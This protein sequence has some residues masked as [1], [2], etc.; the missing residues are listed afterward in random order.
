MLLGVHI[1]DVSFYV[2]EGSP[3]DREAAQRGTSVYLPDQVI[4]MLP[5][6]LSHD[7]CCLQP[8][9]DRLTLS[10]CIELAADGRMGRYEVVDTVIRSQA[11][12]TYTQVAAYLDGNPTH[13]S[14]NP[15]IGAVLA[16]MDHLASVLRQQ[17]LT[18][19]SLD[20]DLPEADI[21]LNSEGKI[22]TILRAERT[23][24]HML[25]EEFM[26]LANRTVAAHLARL[27]VPALYRVHE[28]PSAEKLMPFSAFVRTFGY[29]LPDTGRLQSRA[30]QTLLD[31]AQGTPAAPLINHLLLHHCRGRIMP[32]KTGPFRPACTHYTHF[33][34]PIRRP[35]LIVH[36]LLRVDIAGRGCHVSVRVLAFCLSDCHIHFHERAVADDAEREGY[37]SKKVC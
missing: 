23:R 14:W 6:R 26:L 7:I 21:V 28:P 2:Q 33:T 16:R 27:G 29:A 4:P 37:M 31:A 32:W 25:I 35:G 13:D 5:A 18:A 3:I 17:R 1:A 19:G 9:V 15:A 20:F 36:R 34:S 24:A 8:A 30:V 10:I 12:L 11:R 22:D